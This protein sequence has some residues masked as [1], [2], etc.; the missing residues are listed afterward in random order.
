M[1]LPLGLVGAGAR[2][3]WP[4]APGS[5]TEDDFR[6]E[7]GAGLCIVAEGAG[8]IGGQ[9]KP[10][11]KLAVWSVVGEVLARAPGTSAAQR[12]DR[13]VARADEAIERLTWSWPPG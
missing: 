5:Y 3:C 1:D 6:I 2:A 7:P 4:D 11:G 13:G 9:G 8:A 12:L 10:A